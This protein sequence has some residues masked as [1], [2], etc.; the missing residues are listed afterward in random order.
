M[1]LGAASGTG[2]VAV[3]TGAAGFIG[4][5]LVTAL[6]GQDWRVIPVG[7][8][9]S[10]A[11]RSD[12]FVGMELPCDELGRLLR[13][14]R[15]Q[16][17]VHCAGP[18]SVPES[19]RSPERDFAGTVP[20]VFDL[21]NQVRC[22]SPQ[23]RVL[24]VS[25]AAV[26]GNPSLLPVS[27]TDQT[28]PISPYGFHRLHCEALVEEHRALYGLQAAS[29]RVF[30]AYGP[31]L[32]RQ[33]V[34]DLCRRALTNHRLQLPGL[35]VETRDFIHVEDIAAAV[36]VMAESAAPW[37]SVY[38]LASGIE[39]PIAALAEGIVSK[40][41]SSIPIEFDGR[42]PMGMPLR[43]CADVSRLSALGFRARRRVL[44]DLD[45]ILELA[46]AEA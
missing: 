12:Q 39:T 16:L 17:V 19:V 8:D 2:Q 38:N 44:D 10:V 23:S 34:W 35:G 4:S 5:H 41:E 27:E 1:I 37:E 14:E 30:S 6:R 9:A 7:R 29:L 33:V 13:S 28:L 22:H 43:W 36:I 11:R 20:V 18:S 45:S 31:G 21:L 32:R 15:P 26:Y 42:S 46:G 3:V 24:F 25:S 40:L